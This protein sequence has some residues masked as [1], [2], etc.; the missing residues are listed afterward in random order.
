MIIFAEELFH[1]LLDLSRLPEDGLVKGDEL[2]EFRTSL[3]GMGPLQETTK[4]QCI[5]YFK[6]F[7]Y[8]VSPSKC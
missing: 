8:L 1:T 3:P 2:S 6:C 4:S 5:G 7:L